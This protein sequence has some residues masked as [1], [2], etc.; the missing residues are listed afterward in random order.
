MQNKLQY[1]KNTWTY[2]HK[3]LI[4]CLA[5]IVA[6]IYPLIEWPTLH[7][8]EITY[9]KPPT[10]IYSL[11]TEIAKRTLELYE[12]NRNIDLER[13]RL[14]AIGEINKELQ[15]K[16]YTSDHVDYEELKAKYGY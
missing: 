13:Y 8:E 3:M 1:I 12:Q 5:L 6:H 7:A 14:D 16:V 4:I 9:T 10:I 15:N 11:D 2:N